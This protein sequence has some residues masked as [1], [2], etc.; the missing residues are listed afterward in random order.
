MAGSW[1]YV[2]DA[3]YTE[4]DVDGDSMISPGDINTFDK[5]PVTVVSRED[6]SIVATGT[7]D[8]TCT[9]VPTFAIERDFCQFSFD[10]GAAGSISIQGPLEKVG[11]SYWY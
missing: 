4:V 8:G 6:G 1:S 5:A 11:R 7:L 10:F 3:S 2:T 9:V